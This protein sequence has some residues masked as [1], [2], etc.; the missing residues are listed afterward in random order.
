MRC[1]SHA[2]QKSLL[3]FYV[4]AFVHGME[5]GVLALGVLFS[6]LPKIYN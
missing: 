6:S 5:F 2:L 4:L 1:K 3:Y